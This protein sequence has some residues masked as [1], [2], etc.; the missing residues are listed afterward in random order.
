MREDPSNKTVSL[1]GSCIH[2]GC[3]R[4]VQ[5]RR[6]PVLL[7]EQRQEQTLEAKH[8]SEGLYCTPLGQRHDERPGARVTHEDHQLS[9]PWV[10]GREMERMSQVNLDDLKGR[11]QNGSEWGTT[12]EACVPERGAHG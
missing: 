9:Y 6:D 7:D 2:L 8:D 12:F 4:E 11:R 1:T 5:Q 10:L 3:I